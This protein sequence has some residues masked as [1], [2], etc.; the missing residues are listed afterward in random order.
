MI[1]GSAPFFASALKSLPAISFFLSLLNACRLNQSP[2]PFFG[3]WADLIAVL[4]LSCFLL[5]FLLLSLESDPAVV[6]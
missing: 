3:P 5:S 6:P 4:L 2:E 1:I